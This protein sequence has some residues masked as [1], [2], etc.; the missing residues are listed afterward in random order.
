MGIAAEDRQAAVRAVT[1]TAYTYEEDWH[2]L[3]DLAGLDYGHYNDRLLAWINLELGASFQNINDA[4][5]AFAQS[6]S[7]GSWSQMGTFT[8]RLPGVSRA[9]YA[10]HVAASHTGNTSETTLKTYSIPANSLGANGWIEVYL[11]AGPHT[12]SANAKTYRVKY[13]G[14][15]FAALAATTSVTG[16]FIIRISNMNV[17]NAQN[18][19]TSSAGISSGF[20]TNAALTGTIDTTAAQDLTITGQLANSG[21]SIAVYGVEISTVYMG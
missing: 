7:A 6:Q 14:T 21:E 4:M 20:S 12:N 3:F 13:G 2:V 11:N 1:G 16:K 9:L 8:M 10:D 19:G 15:S 17:T 5:L 18:S